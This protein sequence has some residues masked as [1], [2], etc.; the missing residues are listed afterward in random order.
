MSCNLV[1]TLNWKYI[2]VHPLMQFEYKSRQQILFNFATKNEK[3]C[4]MLTSI[5]FYSFGEK[6]FFQ[7][8]HIFQSQTERNHQKK[9]HS[10]FYCDP[11]VKRVFETSQIFE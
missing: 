10:Y 9:L 5:K 11:R 3:R 8:P 6:F 7:L 4:Q 2:V 1:M